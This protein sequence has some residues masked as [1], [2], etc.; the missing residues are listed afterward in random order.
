M[1]PYSSKA[2]QVTGHQC[3]VH[4]NAHTS[5]TRRR[6]TG[7]SGG[8]SQQQQP[9]PAASAPIHALCVCVHTRRHAGC[10]QTPE[11][12]LLGKGTVTLNLAIFTYGRHDQVFTSVRIYSASSLLRSH[13]PARPREPALRSD[14]AA[15]PALLFVVDHHRDCTTHPLR[16]RTSRTAHTLAEWPGNSASRNTEQGH[17]GRCRPYRDFPCF[18]KAIIDLSAL[19]H[20]DA[21]PSPHGLPVACMRHV[22]RGLRFCECPLLRRTCPL[23]LARHLGAVAPAALSL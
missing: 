21:P 8:I 14:R 23:A 6:I 3:S 18:T 17:S 19:G 5:T 1:L 7:T 11:L 13:S 16:E 20:T 22:A 12:S 9:P 10:E 4:A 2:T 15:V